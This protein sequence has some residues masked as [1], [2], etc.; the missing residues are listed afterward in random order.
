MSR[1][2]SHFPRTL[3]ARMA[4]HPLDTITTRVELRYVTA[5]AALPR[6]SAVEGIESV[7]R[8]SCSSKTKGPTQVRTTPKADGIAKCLW[9]ITVPQLIFPLESSDPLRRKGGFINSP[10]LC[11]T[12]GR[13]PI[14]SE[15]PSKF[16]FPEFDGRQTPTR[17][18]PHRTRSVET[19]PTPLFL[20]TPRRLRY[21]AVPGWKEVFRLRHMR[22]TSRTSVLLPP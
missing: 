12:V 1:E 19:G 4:S 16:N 22:L 13:K 2:E 10:D 20:N 21:S 11:Q 18:R 8:V 9:V 3:I 5:T 14:C 6:E 15:P 7:E 17:R